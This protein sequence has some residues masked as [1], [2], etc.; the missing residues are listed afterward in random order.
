VRASSGPF[1]KIFRVLTRGHLFLCLA[2]ACL[3][4][5]LMRSAVGK[6]DTDSRSEVLQRWCRRLLSCLRVQVSVFGTIPSR[7]LIVSNHLSY[8]DIFVFSAT[9]R[10]MFVSKS[11][12]K[13][14]PLVGWVARMTG[15]VF[16]DRARRSQT[17]V[18]QLQMQERLSAGGLLVLFPEAT[19]T[20]SREL[21][22]FRSSFFE[23][24]VAVAAPVTAAHI[25][26]ELPEGDGDPVT[27]I[28]YWGEMTLFPH[29]IKL[30]TKTRIQA[31]V[32][33]SGQP[34]TFPNR[35]Q[36]AK[37]MQREVAELGNVAS[38][39]AQMILR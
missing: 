9:A 39:S 16:V 13:S 7:G 23:A 8:V 21:L 37:E 5:C 28:C 30:L 6:L 27:D 24:A 2:C 33:F 22:P 15:T 12:I 11:E 1:L 32:R 4:E 36:A 25:S 20:N 38:S 34:R 10:C 18:P 31:T 29:L 14:W 19:S 17:D 35:K 3:A 26:Y